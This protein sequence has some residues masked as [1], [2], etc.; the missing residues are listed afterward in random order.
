M[1]LINDEEFLYTSPIY[2]Y[3]SKTLEF[4]PKWP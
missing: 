4:D 1:V 2:G 3:L